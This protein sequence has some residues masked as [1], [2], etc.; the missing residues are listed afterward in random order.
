MGLDPYTVTQA[1][2]AL[3]PLHGP[4]VVGISLSR[5]SALEE[6]HRSG[7][8]SRIVLLVAAEI[9]PDIPPSARVHPL[10]ACGPAEV[11]D[12]LDP[13][14]SDDFIATPWSDPE[15]RYRVRKLLSARRWSSPEGTLTW[16]K[17]WLQGEDRDGRVAR[18]SLST[19]EY[20]ILDIIIRAGGLTVERQVLGI[21]LGAPGESSRSLDMQ[22]SRARRKL[23]AVSGEWRVPPVIE[24]RRGMGYYLGCP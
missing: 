13:G 22:V 16:G 23:K 12:H 24:S 15:L 19:G 2:R 4:E 7:I 1:R 21:I 8:P 18:V 6:D 20:Q 17:L 11:V 9:L 3:V 14:A 5:L 10:L